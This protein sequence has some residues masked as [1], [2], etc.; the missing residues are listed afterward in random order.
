[1]IIFK[2]PLSIVITHHFP[3]ESRTCNWL[4]PINV[5]LTPT[6]W[7]E[8]PQLRL[9]LFFIGEII[10]GWLWLVG[11]LNFVTPLF[12]S[13]IN[14]I[15]LILT[16]IAKQSCFERLRD[17]VSASNPQSSSLTTSPPN[18][19]LPCPAVCL[20]FL[21]NF[22]IPRLLIIIILMHWAIFL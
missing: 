3:W 10:W 19:A 16:R 7:E 18:N 21:T 9:F 13:G 8:L 4:L 2:H 15:R 6:A 17:L 5:Q 22:L 11:M 12:N 1:M 14:E 20:H